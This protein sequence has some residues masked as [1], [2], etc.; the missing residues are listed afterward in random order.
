M[1]IQHIQQ[2]LHSDESYRIE[3]TVTISN[4]DKLQEAICSF[5]NDLSGS[6]LKGYLLIGVKDD[7]TVA[8]I[9]IDD[10]IMKE[11]SALRSTGNILPLPIMHTE[12]V[13]LP[14][15]DILVVEVTP[16]YFP[17]VRYRGRTFI[18]IGPRKDI[19]TP[20][21]ERLLAER[22]AQSLP[23]FDLVPCR[24]ATLDDLD[25]EYIRTH[26]LPSAIDEEIL[27]SDKRDIKDQLIALRLYNRTH[28]CPTMAAIVLF[29]KNPKY[30]LP[31]CYVQYVRFSGKDNSS[32]IEN[33]REFKGSLSKLLPRLES[34]VED[35]VI[36]QRPAPVSLF[37]E[38]T[39]TNYPYMAL[40]ELIMNAC[41]HRDYQ[42]TSPIRIY[43]YANRIEI[44]NSG[45]LYGDAR[46]ENFPTVN[47]Y[48]NPVIAEA[49]KVMKYV[50]MFNRG[51]TRV[52]T[53]LEDNGSE[54]A[55]FVIDKLTV[56]QVV[57]E[58]AN[59][60][61][62]RL[63]IPHITAQ[64]KEKHIS[65]KSD[66]ISDKSDNISDKYLISHKLLA[67]AT[68]L[69]SDKIAVSPFING[70]KVGKKTI[71]NLSEITALLSIRKCVTTDEIAQYLKLSNP[72]ARALLQKLREL[73]ILEADGSNK[74]RT[75][76]LKKQSE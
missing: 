49:M 65:D 1:E 7:G 27:A 39:V 64:E 15:G 73:Q 29:G 40:R 51:V 42:S 41:M 35:A 8:G 46:P 59:M 56:F 32:E 74:N 76:S 71:N 24:E 22:S 13:S 20:E 60:R 11:I 57:L 61:D 45:G 55:H 12:K 30:F 34:F 9:T 68:T 26:Y 44:T 25:I 18:R 28:D 70:R 31:G 37:R 14:D 6:G 62:E 66:N 47:A 43:Q 4:K 53:L 3:R 52:Q 75:Y 50:N 38:K 63:G 10:K 48:R 19:A 36:N 17:P 33:E 72:S 58:D 5:A 2:L 69:V 23:N 54:P 16:S 21:E 67:A